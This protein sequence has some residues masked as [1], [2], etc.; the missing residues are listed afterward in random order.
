MPSLAGAGSAQVSGVADW[1]VGGSL[2]AH[3]RCDGVRAALLLHQAVCW[4]GAAAATE[5]RAGVQVAKRRG[6]PLSKQ[7]LVQHCLWD[8]SLL[9]FVCQMVGASVRAG[10]G[11]GQSGGCCQA[12]S[13]YTSTVMAVLE[14]ASPQQREAV[15]GLVVPY[16]ERGFKSREQNYRA[17]SYIIVSGLAVLATMEAPL[18]ESLLYRVSKVRAV[19]FCGFLSLVLPVAESV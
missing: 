7:T 10:K 17:S 2:P 6:C 5:P 13:L 15:V 8:L 11:C 12:V 14:S 16:V 18:L 9:H 4:C 1:R 19:V 3:G